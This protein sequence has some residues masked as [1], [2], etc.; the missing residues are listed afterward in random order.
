MENF[1]PRTVNSFENDDDAKEYIN[2]YFFICNDEQ[3]RILINDKVE[4]ITED[5]IKR[6]YFRTI[7]DKQL[8][9]W[10][11]TENDTLHYVN[12]EDGSID[13]EQPKP[14]KKK[15]KKK[16]ETEKPKKKQTKETE[17]D[18]MVDGIDIDIDNAIDGDYED[19]KPKKKGKKNMLIFE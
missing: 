3:Y 1:Q 8:I 2:R 6:V 13:T 18:K 17:C 11:F 4:I 14:K 15:P 19:V 16:K 5:K 10:F 7:K 9:E 12:N